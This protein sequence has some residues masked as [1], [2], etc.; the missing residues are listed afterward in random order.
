MTDAGA[1][2]WG[3]AWRNK[4]QAALAIA[5]GLITIVAALV[6]LFFYFRDSG[7]IASYRSASSCAT[8]GDAVAGDG[9]RYEGQ[10]R[11][12]S[13]SRHDRLEAV[14]SFDSLPGRTFSTSFP[15]SD[16]PDSTALKVGATAN[17]E[18]WAGK[19]TQLA[20]KGTLDDPEPYPTTPLLVMAAILGVVGLV[21]LFLSGQLAR[22]AWRPR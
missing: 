7:L 5:V 8:A 15:N 11:V 2:P 18:L 20:G 4:A 14:V 21:I 6:L 12:L 1:V 19:V 17:G 22:A 13:V 10:A 9:C 16:E 3:A